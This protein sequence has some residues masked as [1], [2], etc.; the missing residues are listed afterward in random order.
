MPAPAP[1]PPASGS[2]HDATECAQNR[3]YQGAQKQT[4]QGMPATLVLRVEGP[5]AIGG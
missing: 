2:Q 3:P 4:K 5:A 1:A